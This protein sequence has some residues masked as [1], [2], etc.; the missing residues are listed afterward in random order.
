[1]ISHWTG[2]W[3]DLFEGLKLSM[4]LKSRLGLRLEL[5][6]RLGLGRLWLVVGGGQGSDVGSPGSEGD[7]VLFGAGFQERLGYGDPS[8]EAAE[9]ERERKRPRGRERKRANEREEMIKRGRKWEMDK[10]TKR[11]Q[12]WEQ[13]CT[14][15][16]RRKWSR[17]NKKNCDYKCQAR[18]GRNMDQGELT[19]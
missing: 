17:D 11:K 3:L 10:Q 5:G 8:R 15:K 18:G 2:Q 1:M 4:G 12:K 13:K 14:E 19:K 16:L 6:M 9:K 7:R